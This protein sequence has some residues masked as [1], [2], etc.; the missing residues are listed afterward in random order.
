MDMHLAGETAKVR[1]VGK[2]A[3]DPQTAISA[4]EGKPLEVNDFDE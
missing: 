4:S 1:L 2:H 3:I